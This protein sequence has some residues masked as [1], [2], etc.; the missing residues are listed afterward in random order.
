MRQR[1][2]FLLF[3]FSQ[4]HLDIL[5]DFTFHDVWK[6][7]NIKMEFQLSKKIYH[8][9]ILV[10]LFQWHPFIQMS[11]FVNSNMNYLLT[12]L[13]EFRNS[14]GLNRCSIQLNDKTF[15]RKI[16]FSMKYGWLMLCNF[17]SKYRVDLHRYSSNFQTKLKYFSLLHVLC[18][19]M[20]FDRNINQLSK[21]MN[22]IW[23]TF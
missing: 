6:L 2:L 21:N 18:Y 23:M 22:R 7:V 11:D 8:L 19:S 16:R 12:Q 15:I 4:V 17:V 9:I 14:T 20:N 3:P 1:R 5:M 13:S 10:S